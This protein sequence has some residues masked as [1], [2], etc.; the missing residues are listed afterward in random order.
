MAS[1]PLPF[2]SPQPLSWCRQRSQEKDLALNTALCLQQPR[3]VRG[4][5]FLAVQWAQFQ[6]PL[7]SVPSGQMAILLCARK[8]FFNRVH[9]HSKP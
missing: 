3:R 4:A 5:R 9:C 8:G 6:L 1:H 7:K 2:L